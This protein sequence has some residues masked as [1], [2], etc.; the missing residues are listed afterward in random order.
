MKTPGTEL[1]VTVQTEVKGKLPDLD[2][3]KL[4]K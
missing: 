3:D 1:R 2:R 4:R